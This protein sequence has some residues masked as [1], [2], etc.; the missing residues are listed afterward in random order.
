MPTHGD[1]PKGPVTGAETVASPT[2][3]FAVPKQPKQPLINLAGLA[4]T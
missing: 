2:P 3:Q 4:E 1:W